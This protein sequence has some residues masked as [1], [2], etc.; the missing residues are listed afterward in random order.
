M[1]KKDSSNDMN[2]SNSYSSNNDNGSN[3]PSPNLNYLTNTSDN[4][5]K[6]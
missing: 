1:P 5:T 2:H 3:R 6:W 4:S